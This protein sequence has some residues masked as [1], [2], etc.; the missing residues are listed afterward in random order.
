MKI[1][2]SSSIKKLDAYTIENEP[3]ASVS[4]THLDVYKR[5][6]QDTTGIYSQSTCGE[7]FIMMNIGTD[8]S[9]FYLF[10]RHSGI[11][12]VYKRQPTTVLPTITVVMDVANI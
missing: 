12:D 9:Y 6:R 8:A 4:Y 11:Q 5:Q 2:P 7:E 10:C 3:I 1:F